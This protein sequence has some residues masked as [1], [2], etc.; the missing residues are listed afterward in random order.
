MLKNLKHIWKNR[1]DHWK[2]ARVTP[3]TLLNKFIRINIKFPLSAIP[4]GLTDSL[5]K[6]E[7]S[8]YENSI[9]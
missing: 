4:S 8:K 1:L 5:Y 6:F 7:C 9:T 2:N 3:Q